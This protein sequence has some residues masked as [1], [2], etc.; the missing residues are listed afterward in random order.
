MLAAVAVWGAA[1]AGF[2]VV[3]GLWPTLIL[4][5]VAGAADVFTVVFRGIIVAALTPDQLRGRV[6]AADYVVGAGGGQI[7]NLEAG[8]LGSLT[9]PGISALT[10][11]LV[12][13][14]G[15]IVIGLALPAFTR[16]RHQSDRPR[17]KSLPAAV[18]AQT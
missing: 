18:P 5:A 8:A 3:P 13:V 14:A 7:G 1:F 9:S 10:G 11:G 4:L 15:A 12:T 16:Y 2:A 6:M 17:G